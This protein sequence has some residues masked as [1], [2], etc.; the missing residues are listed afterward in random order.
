[1]RVLKYKLDDGWKTIISFSGN[2]LVGAGEETT[3]KR[4][5]RGWRWYK[6]LWSPKSIVTYFIVYLESDSTIGWG[7][8][9]AIYAYDYHITDVGHWVTMHLVHRH[10]V[11]GLHGQGQPQRVL[12][13]P[14][15]NANLKISKM[16]AIFAYTHA[17]TCGCLFEL[18]KSL[19][20]A[21]WWAS[22]YIFDLTILGFILTT[23]ES[24]LNTLSAVDYFV[25]VWRILPKPCRPYE[26]VDYS[27][28]KFL[29]AWILLR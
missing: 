15:L 14:I 24:I 12:G 4:Q 21:S 11:L 8:W 3:P 16:V 23:V 7:H 19:D 17:T 13:S 1:M 26:N 10:E 20:E 25:S 22:Y 2:P 27:S 5:L 6:F 29:S 28:P 9:L 18:C